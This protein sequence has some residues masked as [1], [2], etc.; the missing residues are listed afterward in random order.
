MVEVVEVLVDVV[1]VLAG[2]DDALSGSLITMVLCSG[3][4]GIELLDPSATRIISNRTRRCNWRTV[5]SLISALSRSSSRS[6]GKRLLGIS[7]GFSAF[8]SA[9][10]GLAVVGRR[11]VEV[12][13][14]VVVVEVV[15]VVAGVGAL[16]SSF[17]LS[18]RLWP[19]RLQ[20]R[21]GL[22]LS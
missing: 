14:V 1:L 22:L 21:S 11:V 12:V 4:S 3:P 8:F 18:R 17:R 16:V 10:V 15:E 7:F 20:R 9:R 2:T 13:V 6:C 5:A 19:S